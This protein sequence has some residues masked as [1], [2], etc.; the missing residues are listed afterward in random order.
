MKTSAILGSLIFALKKANIGSILALF[1]MTASIVTVM[2]LK[3][4]ENN[5]LA[6]SKTQ[7]SSETGW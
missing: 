3:T 4:M 2:S 7:E 6:F 1:Q 5:G